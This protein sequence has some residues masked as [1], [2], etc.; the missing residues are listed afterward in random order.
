MLA[1]VLAA[2]CP[3]CLA[4]ARAQ[5]RGDIISAEVIVSLTGEEVGHAVRE[6]AEGVP[7]ILIQLF[8]PTDH[9]VMGIR[10]V[11]HTI[12]GQGQPTI[13]SG[14]PSKQIPAGKTMCIQESKCQSDDRRIGPVPAQETYTW[15]CRELR[16]LL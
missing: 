16:R 4:S 8:V 13:A 11:Y 15:G 5:N 7:E 10:V 1:V 9:D 12:D 14:L 3:L 2:V 6:V